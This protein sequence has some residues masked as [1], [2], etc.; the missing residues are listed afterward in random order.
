MGQMSSQTH[1]PVFTHP[2]DEGLLADDSHTLVVTTQASPA[3]GQ[4][5]AP[6]LR[7]VGLFLSLGLTGWWIS[8]AGSFRGL[9]SASPLQ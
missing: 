2:Q 9:P 8:E 3:P 1:T 5:P 7:T 4:T 6:G